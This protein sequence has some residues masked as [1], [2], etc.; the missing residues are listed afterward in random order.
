MEWLA[1]E[2]ATHE[3]GELEPGKW[4]ANWEATELG[5]SWDG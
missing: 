3:S 4:S 2:L 5:W 1:Y